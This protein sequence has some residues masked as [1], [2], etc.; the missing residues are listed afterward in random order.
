VE[1]E[2]EAEEEEEE[3]EEEAE[4]EVQRHL[5]ELHHFL[6]TPSPYRLHFKRVLFTQHCSF[7]VLNTCSLNFKSAG[8][9]TMKCGR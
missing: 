8:C 9:M 7:L 4:E 1:E 3:G 5:Q 6:L 2:E